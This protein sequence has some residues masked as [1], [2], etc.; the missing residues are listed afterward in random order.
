[1]LGE[2]PLQ[3]ALGRGPA[4]PLAPTTTAQSAQGQLSPWQVSCSHGSG[5][6]EPFLWGPCEPGP[7]PPGPTNGVTLNYR[8]HALTVLGPGPP[9]PG[10]AG[11]CSLLGLQGRVPPASPRSGGSRHPRACGHITQSLSR[12]HEAT[13]LC[14]SRGHTRH[15][16]PPSLP[17][18]VRPHL[19]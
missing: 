17:L 19:N 16:L 3:K 10:V 14:V 11:P 15:W 6:T 7:P 8:E 4:H 12:L 9:D 13:S 1:M 2:W 18:P 5:L